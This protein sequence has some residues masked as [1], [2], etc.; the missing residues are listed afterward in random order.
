MIPGW[1][2]PVLAFLGSLAWIGVAACVVAMLADLSGRTE[3]VEK[4]AEAVTIRLPNALA[5][6]GYPTVL[7]V[8]F[9]NASNRGSHRRSLALGSIPEKKSA[10]ESSFQARSSSWNASSRCPSASRS[11]A[12]W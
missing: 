5:V 11:K 10:Y 4:Y 6:S 2:N 3:S 12:R 9:R 7:A 1:L 8:F